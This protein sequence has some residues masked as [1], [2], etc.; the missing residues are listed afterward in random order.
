MCL[1]PTVSSFVRHAD[2]RAVREAGRLCR[3]P[4]IYFSVPLAHM[5]F[6][7]VAPRLPALK[8]CNKLEIALGNT[9][10]GQLRR[11]LSILLPE[12]FQIG[13]GTHLL[14]LGHPYCC[15]SNNELPCSTG[16]L[17][18]TGLTTLGKLAEHMKTCCGT[19]MI[20]QGGNCSQCN[21]PFGD[22][23]T[24]P[25]FDWTNPCD[26]WMQTNSG[27]ANANVL[28][29]QVASSFDVQT[30]DMFHTATI[31]TSMPHYDDE[32]LRTHWPYNVIANQINQI[33]KSYAR[34]P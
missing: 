14:G 9:F 33:A 20:M 6:N 12:L 16:S 11:Q 24:V 13:N 30:V 8:W 22:G 26:R 7:P 4:T 5:L 29:A 15:G 3:Q 25:H 32:C 34:V 2:D 27:M 1:L 21:L 31:N 18:E 19:S 17:Y 10:E 28:V 23:A